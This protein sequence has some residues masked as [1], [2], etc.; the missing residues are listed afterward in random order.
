MKSKTEP[1]FEPAQ[2]GS[3]LTEYVVVSA[4]L[5]LIFTL[6]DD[7]LALFQEHHDEFSSALQ[8]PF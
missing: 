3:V 7:L 8:L 5:L 6:L 1:N 2:R 4:S